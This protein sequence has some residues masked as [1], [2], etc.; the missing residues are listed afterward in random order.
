MNNTQIK[1][2]EQIKAGKLNPLFVKQNREEYDWYWMVLDGDKDQDVFNN[3]SRGDCFNASIIEIDMSD[4]DYFLQIA[5][6][7]LGCWRG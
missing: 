5:D 3:G 2:A 4:L 6:C 1:V 7:G